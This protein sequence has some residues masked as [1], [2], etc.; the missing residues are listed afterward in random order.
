M[1]SS[2]NND[3]F[4]IKHTILLLLDGTDFGKSASSEVKILNN[5]WIQI[6]QLLSSMKTTV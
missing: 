2:L 4:L 6:K 5:F 1:R 3:T